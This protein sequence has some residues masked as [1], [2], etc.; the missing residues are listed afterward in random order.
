MVRGFCGNWRKNVGCKYGSIFFFGNRDLSTITLMKR[1]NP[2]T[3]TVHTYLERLFFMWEEGLFTFSHIIPWYYEQMAS[4]YLWVGWYGGLPFLPQHFWI[5]I[6]WMILCHCHSSKCHPCHPWIES[7]GSVHCQAETLAMV[8]QNA[9]D[10]MEVDQ[11][12]EFDCYCRSKKGVSENGGTPK[13]SIL[14]GFSI[15][16]HPFWG[17][18]IFGNTQKLPCRFFFNKT[19]NV[20]LANLGRVGGDIW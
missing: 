8:S 6:L 5:E 7:S 18:P 19:P 17:A 12:Q 20:F 3:D 2:R 16:N 1:Q 11:F 4:W 10:T 14:I 15:I 9:L 13:S